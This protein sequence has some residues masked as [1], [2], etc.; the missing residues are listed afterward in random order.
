MGQG[1]LF[2]LMGPRLSNW[3][4]F[5][6]MDAMGPYISQAAVALI[7]LGLFVNRAVREGSKQYF[8]V[9]SLV[10]FFCARVFLI[11]GHR[12]H[13][14]DLTWFEWLGIPVDAGFATALILYRTRGIQSDAA[15]PLVALDAEVVAK[16]ALIRLQ[17]MA[18]KLSKG[19]VPAPKTAEAAPAATT[20]PAPIVAVE[21][22]SVE[23]APV[24]AATPSAVLAPPPPSNSAPAAPVAPPPP[25][26]PISTALP[27]M[28]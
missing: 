12:L 17:S 27:H 26:K 13:G 24:E 14:Y 21:A 28:D 16:D 4:S 20:A 1:A 19:R 18:S 2:F 6:Y 11:L 5:R 23:P 22:L 7:C 8:A 10:L 9:D 25:P 3:L 15:E